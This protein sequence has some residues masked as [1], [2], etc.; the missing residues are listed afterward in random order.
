MTLDHIA[1]IISKEEHLAFYKKLGFK[2]TDRFPRENDTV[3]FMENNG[4]VLEIFID[5]NHPQRL[6]NPEPSGLWHF[7][8][9]VDDFDTFIKDF[10][11]EEI[12]TNWFGQRLT[13]T[14]DPDGQPVEFMEKRKN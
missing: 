6:S 4:I 11:C 2:E 5:P 1:I 14:R 9:A 3:V 10:E 8:L 13:F 7:A 12:Q